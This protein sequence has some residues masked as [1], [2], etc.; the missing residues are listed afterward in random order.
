[1]FSPRILRTKFA[2]PALFA[3]AALTL[4]SAPAHAQNTFNISDPSF[5]GMT[6][7]TVTVP[8]KWQGQGVLFEPGACASTPSFVFRASSPDGLSYVERMPAFA[9]SWGT[10]PVALKNTKDCFPA[11]TQIPA[12]EF[13]KYMA[14]TLNVEYVSDA[15]VP[16]AQRAMIQ[17]QQDEA[18]SRG[19]GGGGMRQTKSMDIARAYIRSKNGTF[20]M[21]GRLEALVDCN[22]NIIPGFKSPNPSMPAQPG[23]DMYVC[24]A[25]VRYTV[26]PEA[27]FATVEKMWDAEGMGGQPNQQWLQAWWQ[28]KNDLQQAENARNIQAQKDLIVAQQRQFDHDQIVRRQMH[29][30]FTDASMARTRSHCPDGILKFWPDHAGQNMRDLNKSVGRLVISNPYGSYVS[31]LPVDP[32]HRPLSEHCCSRGVFGHSGRLRSRE[33]SDWSF[34]LMKLQRATLP[35]GYSDAV[36]PAATAMVCGRRQRLYIPAPDRR[37]PTP[38]RCWSHL[39]PALSPPPTNIV[40]PLVALFP[41]LISLGTVSG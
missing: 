9:W 31:A 28:R 32:T 3:T 5:G 2:I 37:R 40:S 14:K 20:V 11:N 17:K 25:A 7:A 27:Q 13:L 8:A 39:A 4:A 23:T 33:Q 29:E 24:T 19:P 41:P 6:A 26:A 38:N 35:T 16:A 12:Q 18:N 22:H 36:E 21:K 15:A 1:M 30:Q 10:G 34:A